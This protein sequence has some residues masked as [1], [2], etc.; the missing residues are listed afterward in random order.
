MEVC[1]EGRHTVDKGIGKTNVYLVICGWYGKT[2]AEKRDR[3]RG[4]V[5]ASVCA[6][7]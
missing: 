5:Y 3:E 1:V 2:E 6:W 4:K 7:E